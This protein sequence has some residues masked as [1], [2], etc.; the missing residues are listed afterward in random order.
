LYC[1]VKDKIVSYDYHGF[2]PAY[3]KF[4]PGTVLQI[5]AFEALFAEQRFTTFDFTEGEGWHKERF[6]TG[7][8]LCGDVY[9]ISPRVMPISLILLHHTVNITSAA[10][11]TLLDRVRLKSTVRQLLRGTWGMLYLASATTVD[12]LTLF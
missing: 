8:R 6:S 1:K 5:L 2:D 7:Y 12:D 10:A 11:G 4:S 9:V 3:A